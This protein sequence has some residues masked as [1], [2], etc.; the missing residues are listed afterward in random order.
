MSDVIGRG[1]IEV[2][3][4]AAKL[5]AGIADA[6]KTIQSLGSTTAEVTRSSSASID[7]YVRSLAVAAAT[8]GK[9]TREAELLR[10][11][12]RGATDAQIKAADAALR[13]SEAHESS[14]VMMGRVR[15]GLIAVAAAGVAAAGAFGASLIQQINYLDHL[16]DLSKTTG[17]AVGELAGLGLA[18]KQS[19]TDL[20]GVAD[21]VGKL[22]KNIG[23]EPEKFKELGITAKE[24]LEAFKQLADIFVKIEDPQLRAALGAA[25]LGKSWASAAPLLSEGGQAIGEMVDK[26]KR[27]SKVNEEL[28]GGADKLNDAI[29]ELK[30]TSAGYT[31]LLLGDM[32]T[33]FNKIIAAINEAYQESGKLAALWAG[34]KGV[35]SALFTDEF[36]NARIKIQNLRGEI[37]TLEQNTRNI[38]AAG[39]GLINRWLWGSKE[40]NTKK[41]AELTLQIQSLQDAAEALDKPKPPGPAPDPKLTAAV[42]NFVAEPKSGPKDRDTSEQDARA[43]LALDL[44]LIKRYSEARIN[45]LTN[46]EK[47]IQALRD[48]GRVEERDYFEYRREI[49]DQTTAAQEEALQKEI[50]RLQQEKFTG[51]NATKNELENKR[52]IMDA[53]A[54]LAKVRE[55][56]GAARNILAIA[57]DAANIKRIQQLRDAEDAA[58]DY[59]EAL[60]KGNTIALAGIG[61]GSL[62]RERLSGRASIEDRFT[63]QRRELEKSRRDAEFAGTFGPDA[64]RKYDDELDRIKRFQALALQEYDGY[65]KARLQKES[66]WSVGAQEALRNYADEARNIAKQTENLFTNAFKGMEDALVNFVKT[67]KLDFKSLADSIISD[68]VRIQVRKAITAAVGSGASSDGGLLG[69]LLNWGKGLF[70]GGTAAGTAGITDFAVAGGYVPFGAAGGADWMVGGGGGT[71]SKIAQFRVTP[72]ERIIVQTPEQQARAGAGSVYMPITINAPG[73]DPASEARIYAAIRDLRRD[74]V[75]MVANAV[76]RGGSAR[77]HIRG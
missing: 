1:V 71:D 17:I 47:T 29:A 4:D 68:L 69:G 74:V 9:T 53:E 36:S 18:A 56:A 26:G 55:N 73:A 61:A 35:G 60:K 50:A 75:P 33:G 70:G 39:G 16:N 23:K 13:M 58:N 57:E 6:K 20:D 76:R 48:A 2:S 46:A 37:A 72:G 32:L 44:D 15:S 64:Q 12:L 62:E 52:K 3:A 24:P 38:E 65:F 59:L 8:A 21:A 66:D 40:G 49:L 42:R 34:M 63:Q 77:E 22:S 7:R 45:T 51:D 41:I 19:G 54:Q 5:K 30:A 28:T 31:A 27:L 67:G 43:Q 14:V 25:A 11:G 10:L